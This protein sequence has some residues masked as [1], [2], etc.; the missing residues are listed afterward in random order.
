MIHI[1]S[2]GLSDT[3][4][5]YLR[6]FD[7]SLRSNANIGRYTHLTNCKM[8]SEENVKLGD[9]VHFR[10]LLAYRPHRSKSKVYGFTKFGPLITCNGCY[11]NF[12]LRW[13]EITRVSA[14]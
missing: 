10:V 14:A 2:T 12:Q 6:R 3:L 5:A 4:N 9:V 1:R 8:F 7:S 11:R 13:S